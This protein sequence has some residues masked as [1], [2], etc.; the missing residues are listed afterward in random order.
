MIMA[1]R[2]PDG[3]VVSRSSGYADP[4][5]KTPWTTDTVSA[6]GSVTKSF[7]AV[8]IMQLVQEGK[9]SLDDTI[10]EWFPAQPNGDKITVRMLL[11]HTSGLAASF[12]RN[13]KDPKWSEEWSPIDL[14][15]EA[16]RLGPVDK[17]AAAP[18]IQTPITCCW[19]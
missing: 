18:T 12:R 11:S 2:L 19:E 14:V 13:E 15:A 7:T 10:D 9:L 4:A 5:K 16:N 8:V 3:S 6:L 1:A 17:P